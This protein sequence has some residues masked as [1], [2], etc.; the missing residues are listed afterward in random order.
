MECKSGQKQ[1]TIWYPWD[2]NGYKPEVFFT[3]GVCENGFTMHI[4]T[5][6]TEPK[7]E[8]KAHLEPVH[9]DSCVEWFV[10]F[11]PE[12]CDRYF[13]FEV[14]AGG[15]MYAAFR[16]DRYDYK[17]LELKDIESLNIQATIQEN[18]WEINYTV[19]FE[20]IKKYIPDYRYTNKI[21][22]NFYKCGSQ[23]EY[24]HYGVFQH[25]GTLKP[26]FHRPECFVEILL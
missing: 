11:L 26:D 10:N 18:S 8:A 23:T 7:R 2:E 15:I 19:P 6:E 13:N 14:N 3:L 12:S 20:L 1:Y 21:R 17:V 9:V 24:P 5:K 16:K 22:A 4:K 25:P